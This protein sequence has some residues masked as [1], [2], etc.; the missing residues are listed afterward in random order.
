MTAKDSWKPDISFITYTMHFCSYYQANIEVPMPTANTKMYQITIHT[1][2]T[3]A[4]IP[5]D[6]AVLGLESFQTKNRIRPTIGMQHPSR[7]I[8]SRHYLR[9][10]MLL[11]FA[12]LHNAD[13][14]PHYHQF[15]YHN[16]YNT[17][18]YPPIFPCS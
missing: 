10:Q 12:V 9:P 3:N 8:Q 2:A 15:P 1:T 6:F 16:F 17:S 14:L 7:P 13:I 5:A 4:P 11:V 18:Q